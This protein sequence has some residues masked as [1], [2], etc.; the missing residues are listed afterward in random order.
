[1]PALDVQIVSE[2]LIGLGALP[3]DSFEDGTAEADI[4]SR[5]YPSVRDAILSSH[6]W[7]FATAET[8]LPRLAVEPLASFS[9]AYSLPSGFLR[10]LSL[11]NKANKTNRGVD[12]RIQESR[13]HCSAEEPLLVYIFRPDVAGFPGYFRSALIAKLQAAFALPITENT[14]RATTLLQLAEKSVSEAKTTDSQSQPP[15]RFEDFTLTDVR[16]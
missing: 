7:T 13:L 5:L 11:G 16:S 4:A 15:N 12:Y 14:Q 6:P 9:Y 1:M 8:V 2:A 3:I 10:A